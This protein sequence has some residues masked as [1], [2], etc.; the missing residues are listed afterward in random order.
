LFASADNNDGINLYEIKGDLIPV[1]KRGAGFKIS[2]EIFYVV[3]F[4]PQEKD[5]LVGV[6][7]G[8]KAV[9]LR[10]N[11]SEWSLVKEDEIELG[12]GY[13]INVAFKGD[14]KIAVVVGY[15]NQFVVLEVGR[16][17]TN[18]GQFIIKIKVNSGGGGS[19]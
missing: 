15:F 11:E 13:C 4:H 12:M 17:E 18:P 5:Y 14:G 9:L 3:A 1:E 8:G 10:V 2:G 6:S 7:Y 19:Y 16:N